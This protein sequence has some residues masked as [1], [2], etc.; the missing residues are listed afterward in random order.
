MGEQL[1]AHSEETAASYKIQLA[2]SKNAEQLALVL[3]NLTSTTQAEL[4]QINNTTHSIREN[5][6][7][8]QGQGGRIGYSILL[9]AFRI[10][11]RGISHHRSRPPRYLIRWSEGNLPG[12]HQVSENPIFRIAVIFGHLVWST[13]WFLLSAMM[14]MISSELICV[15]TCLPERVVTPVEVLIFQVKETFRKYRINASLRHRSCYLP[16]DSGRFSSFPVT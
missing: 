2:A 8:T 7:A 3:E 9:N 1:Q 16:R 10:I 5:L 15:L 11:G 6:W 13:T 4:Q 14:V 12:Y